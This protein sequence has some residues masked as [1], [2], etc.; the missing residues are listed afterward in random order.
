MKPHYTD[1][2]VRLYHGDCIEVMRT[3]PDAS[4]DAVVT[5]PPYG[6]EFMGKDWDAP[7]KS[8]TVERVTEGTDDTHPFRDGSDRIR[9]GIGGQ[10]SV[11]FQLWFTEVATE[12]LRV[13]KPGG[14]LLAFGGTR[15]WH[16]LAVAIEDAGFEVRDSI[17]WVYGSGFPKS[18]DVSKAIDKR[19][20]HWRGKAGQA[21][22]GNDAMAGPN[23]ERSDKGEPITAAAQKW[24]GFGTAL[25]PAHEPIVVARKPL[26]SP[27]V[28]VLSVV[29]SGLRERGVEGDI[30][31]TNGHVSGAGRLDHPTSSLSTEARQA[32]GTS[33]VTAVERETLNAARPTDRSSATTTPPG[34]RPTANT[35]APTTASRGANSEM[36]CSTPT[37]ESAPVAA[38][39]NTS[40]SPSTTSTAEGR[41]TERA[42]TARSITNLGARDSH[43]D[44]ESFAGIATGLTGSQATAHIRRLPDGSFVWPDGLPRKVAAGSLTVAQNVLTHGTGALN[45]D[46]CRIAGEQ[47][48]RVGNIEKSEADQQVYGR[49][50]QKSG[51]TPPAGR[52]PANVILDESQAAALDA[53]S[54]V[55]TSNVGLRGSLSSDG[56][57]EGWKR[58][59]HAG[60]NGLRGHADTGGA[61]RFFYVAKASKK[62]RPNVNGV[63]HPTVKPMAL[64]QYL[65]RLVTPPGGTV[66]E[67]FAGSGTTIEAALNEG[68]NV[69]GIEMTDEYLPLIMA[70]IE[71]YGDKLC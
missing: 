55:T 4:V 64:M 1:D 34:G 13:L 53:Q 49:G 67:P 69:I 58:E 57:H 17:A 22:T 46:G 37:A 70:R 61:S 6:L 66:L 71:R 59:A 63:A 3:L 16:R 54:G 42:S 62:E 45:I 32:A 48:L 36:P 65:V 21:T 51:T 7:W 68:F 28:N 12:A 43:P 60:F 19:A 15:T 24:S 23:Y 52:W 40:S 20:G 47:V 25:K 39:S 44:T 41:P 8:G 38:R 26:G 9:F 2:R 35:S 27:A 30:Q 56:S 10:A 33:A 29:E 31:W 14:H 18:L 50:W 5:D 11:G